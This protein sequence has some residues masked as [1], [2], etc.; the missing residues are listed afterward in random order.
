MGNNFPNPFNPLT[1]ISFTLKDNEHVTLEVFNIKGKK[2][3]TLIDKDLE[4]DFHFAEWN[5]KDDNNQDVA[6]GIYIYRLRAGEKAI[7]KK[8]LLMK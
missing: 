8:M 1:A 5:A 7:S 2:V 4:A 3:R 6:S